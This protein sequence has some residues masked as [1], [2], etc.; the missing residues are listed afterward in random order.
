MAFCLLV[1]A[2][3]IPSCLLVVPVSAAP[4]QD[5]FEAYL[6][7][8]IDL[9]GVS[10]VTDRLYLFMTGPGLPANGVTLT[11][12]R[13]RADQG[14]FTI[15]DVANDQT[16][17][18]K[19]NTQRIWNQIDP[20]T[21]KV[22]V[23]STPSDYAHLSGNYK[24]LTVYLKDPADR[25]S[26][27]AQAGTYTL[28]PE[29]HVS[30]ISQTPVTITTAATPGLNITTVPSPEPTITAITP[31]PTRKSGPVPLLVVIALAA[32]VLVFMAGKRKNP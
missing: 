30:T 12:T 26:V 4:D 2:T 18:M 22:Y 1:L 27:G 5:Y 23:S 32:G 13:Q 28:N 9:H 20:G 11:N 29:D 19:W 16:W 25:N 17:S 7:D 31:A 15:I 6:G 8:T 21:Y 14:Q 3:A 24:E 10:Y